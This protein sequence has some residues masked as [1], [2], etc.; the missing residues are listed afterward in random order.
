[1]VG[2]AEQAK[3]RFAEI[4]DLYAAAYTEPPY[5]AGLEHVRQYRRW[6]RGELERPGFTFVAAVD[7][8]DS[9]K[10]AGIA[11]GHVMAVPAD[12]W[13]NA[14]APPLELLDLDVFAVMGWAVSPQLRGTRLGRN[15]WDEL[16]RGRIEKYATLNADPAALA[17]AFY[18]RWGWRV[19]GRIEP[20]LLAP[21]NILIKLLR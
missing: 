1:L 17:H 10:L 3:A 16:L 21:M 8:L 20:S 4:V 19:C 14:T 7:P 13:R 11:Y 18:L 9:T 15:L 12:W 2:A 6:L 5:N